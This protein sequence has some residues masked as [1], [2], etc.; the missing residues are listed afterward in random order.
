MVGEADKVAHNGSDF[1]PWFLQQVRAHDLATR[2]RHLDFLDI[3]Y[4][5]APDTSANDAAAKA[6][7]LRM[8][9]SLWDPTCVDESWI[10]GPASNSQPNPDKVMLIPRMQ[11]LI[12][13]YYPGTKLSIGEFSSTAD[14]DLTGGLLTVDMLGIF[15]RY[16][17]DQATYWVGCF[18]R[19]IRSFVDGI[20]G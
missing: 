5:Y 19:C 17:L 9:R 4:Y 12:E 16:K 6:L 10:S 7:R 13:K 18:S 20:A 11:A 8:S 1:L 14:T 2:K 3:H 15:G